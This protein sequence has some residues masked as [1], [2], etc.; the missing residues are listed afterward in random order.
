M[1]AIFILGANGLLSSRNRAAAHSRGER[2]QKRLSYLKQR[3][4]EPIG[5]DDLAKA[6]KMSKRG[7]HKAFSKNMGQSPGRELRRMRIERAKDL[8]LHSNHRQDVIANLC[9]YRSV[10]SFWVSFRKIMG[11]SPGKFRSR[12]RENPAPNQNRGSGYALDHG[13]A[14]IILLPNAADS[15]PFQ[16]LAR[17]G[18]TNEFPMDN[19]MNVFEGHIAFKGRSKKARLLKGSILLNA[20]PVK[21]GARVSAL[22][23]RQAW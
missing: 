23:G 10:N 19:Q 21:A 3:C 14:A 13:M 15:R 8:L 5:V 17:D 16:Q 22:F 12:F 7:L 2:F 1:N 6:L 9:G 20:L 18:R 4:F 11:E